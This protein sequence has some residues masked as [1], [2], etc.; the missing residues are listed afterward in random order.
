MIVTLLNVACS[1]LSDSILT[2]LCRC[3][4]DK[5]SLEKRVPWN[6]CSCMRIPV[7]RNDSVTLPC[8]VQDRKRQNRAAAAC[9]AAPVR[10]SC[11]KLD[12]HC[13]PT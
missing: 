8:S 11:N 9:L 10:C 1:C 3:D 12:S 2:P 7:L 4:K 5:V 6:C 13:H